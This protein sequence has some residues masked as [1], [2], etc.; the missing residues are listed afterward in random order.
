VIF[1]TVSL[2]PLEELA[3]QALGEGLP[4]LTDGTNQRTATNEARVSSPDPYAK[5]SY[6]SASTDGPNQSS[7]RGFALPERR[8]LENFAP[9]IATR[10]KT[11][12]SALP[13]PNVAFT[14][15]RS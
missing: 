4:Y 9:A 1:G 3:S 5:Y 14:I 13:C 10:S 15:M 12:A 2:R 6:A 11:H 8:E 7:L